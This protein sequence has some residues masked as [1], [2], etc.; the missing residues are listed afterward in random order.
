[1]SNPKAEFITTIAE[2]KK[3]TSGQLP[4]PK[5]PLQ[6]RMDQDLPPIIQNLSLNTK[7]Q[8]RNPIIAALENPQSSLFQQKQVAESCFDVL[9]VEM[10]RTIERTSTDLDKK[11]QK[12]LIQTSSSF[13]STSS[14]PSAT[15][16]NHTSEVEAENSPV[17]E[18]RERDQELQ[19][20]IYA[21][22]ELIGQRVGYALAEKLVADRSTRFQ[23][24]DSNVQ[25]EI[26]KFICK[27]F[28]MFIVG[29]QI[30]NLKTNHKGI[31]VLQ[32]NQFRWLRS[33]QPLDQWS[34]AQLQTIRPLLAYPC[35][36]LKGA[37][38][39][40]GLEA[41]VV[42]EASH[43]SQCTFKLEILSVPTGASSCAPIAR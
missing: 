14:A 24:S 40:L 10:V 8:P 35:G 23:W 31:F 5:S 37:L 2:Q 9:I 43:S 42:A 19:D 11:F 13:T 6:T 30:D 26:M 1:M 20:V 25:L 38:D 3:P 21:K 16:S 36:L 22:I 41:N 15:T 18:K 32:D 27:E 39:N 4:S 34:P 33:L 17:S 7:N 12:F 28:W 29:K